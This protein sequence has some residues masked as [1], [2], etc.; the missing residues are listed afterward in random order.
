M[1]ITRMWEQAHNIELGTKDIREM[2]T[3]FDWF[4]KHI[5]KVNGITPTLNM[6]K[7]L[8]QCLTAPEEQNRR[9][10]RLTNLSTTRFSAYF[11][12]IIVQHGK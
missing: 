7:G 12:A 10:Y 1:W 4:V 5:S 8:E 6:G 3:V 2:T 11:Q 9:L